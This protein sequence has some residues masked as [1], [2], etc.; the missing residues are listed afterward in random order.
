MTSSTCSTTTTSTSST[1]LKNWKLVGVVTL[2]QLGVSSKVIM[3][4]VNTF[5]ACGVLDTKVI[6]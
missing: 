4:V 2:C 1:W 5:D 6:S 3:G